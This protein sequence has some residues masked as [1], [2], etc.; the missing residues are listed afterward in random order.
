MAKSSSGLSD[1]FSPELFKALG[2]PTR[3]AILR[4]LLE[5]DSAHNV[6]EIAA[7]CNVG[8]S[9]VSRHLAVLARAGI[10]ACER[11]G[12]EVLYRVRG[13]DLAALLRRLADALDRG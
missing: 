2:E 12:Q 6:S 1:L 7:R 3:V 13:R 11:R 9:T 10:L 4:R 5:R 8:L